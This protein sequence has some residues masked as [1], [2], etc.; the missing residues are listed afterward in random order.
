MEEGAYQKFLASY[1][2]CIVRIIEN[3]YSQDFEEGENQD[4]MKSLW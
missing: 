3:G 4:E 2:S 1:K